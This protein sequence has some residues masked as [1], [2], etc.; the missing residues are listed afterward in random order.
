MNAKIEGN[1]ILALTDFLEIAR[2]F[3]KK[4]A[5]GTLRIDVRNH[6]IKGVQLNPTKFVKLP[7]D[8]RK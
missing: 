7:I 6:E 5:H 2:E 3:C 4:N 1:N 8:R